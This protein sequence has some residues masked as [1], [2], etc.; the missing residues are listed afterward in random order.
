LT[1]PKTASAIEALSK[2]GIRLVIRKALGL[3]VAIAMTGDV[4]AQDK[5]VYGAGTITCGEW[6]Q[7]RTSGN[8]PAIYQAQA[9]IDGYLS[10]SNASGGGPDFLTP[11]PTSIAYYVWIDNYCA[12][13]PLN[14]LL[15]A[16]FLLEKELASRT[17]LR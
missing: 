15:Q 3:A 11:K 16:V 6:Q 8:K 5:M 4:L 9:W 2:S 12:Q 14:P 7:Y 10:G 17:P 13:N 1:P